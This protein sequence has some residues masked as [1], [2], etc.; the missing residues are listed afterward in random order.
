MAGLKLCLEIKILF[1]KQSV[2]IML[3]SGYVL[4]IGLNMLKYPECDLCKLFLYVTWVLSYHIRFNLYPFHSHTIYTVI[5][6]DWLF[7]EHTFPF[8]HFF[9]VISSYPACIGTI[10]FKFQRELENYELLHFKDI[11]LLFSALWNL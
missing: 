2:D 1:L 6:V 11:H 3:I 4:C 8:F 9:S 10:I 7:I 5:D